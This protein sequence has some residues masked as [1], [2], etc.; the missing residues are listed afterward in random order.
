[1]A[2]PVTFA[3]TES[4]HPGPLSETQAR[5]LYE[6]GSEAVIRKDYGL[7]IKDF[8]KLI[9]RYPSNEKIQSAYLQL[10][11]A[12][13]HEK[14]FE[15]LV[16]YGKDFLNLK[17]DRESANR[18]RAYLAEANLSLHRYLDARLSA[19]ELLK[20]EPSTREKA[21][22]YSVQFQSLVEEKQYKE[23]HTPLDRL[24]TLL[25]KDPL[26]LFLKLMPEF[27]MTLANRE[28][29]TSHLLRNKAFSEEEITDYFTAKN[30][31]YKSALPLTISG[32]AEPVLHEWCANFTFLNHELQKLKIDS[33]LKAKVQSEL[34][35]TLDFAQTL[36]PELAKCY[37][38]YK[39]PVKNKKRH[40]KRGLRSSRR[41]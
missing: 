3:Q 33:F 16:K 15:D 20:N 22:A 37:E 30:L 9:N 31:C 41:R 28:C 2:S 26:E 1:M 29:S 11:D 7:A 21:V 10:M 24:A 35:T 17:T 6:E 39:P 40:R 14:K 25:E 38:P 13:Y 12:F 8:T 18:A 4:P 5:F 23:A 32:V 19:E 34:K 36:S 27:K